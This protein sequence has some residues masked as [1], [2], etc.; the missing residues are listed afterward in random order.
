MRWNLR[1]IW[2]R[3]KYYLK[4]FFPNW[5][6]IAVK[7]PII[8]VI[9]YYVILGLLWVFSTPT[10]CQTCH[11][12]QPYGKQWKE[13]THAN[14]PC[15][16]CHGHRDFIGKIVSKV[17]ALSELYHHITGTYEFPIAP[18]KFTSDHNCTYCHPPTR[19]F[20]LSGDLIDPHEKHHEVHVE[21]PLVVWLNG[22]STVTLEFNGQHCVYCHLNVV[23]ADKEDSRRPQMEFCME[24]CHDGSK[25]T[26]ECDACHT[27]KNVPPS[28]QAADWFEVHGQKQ[29]EEDCAGCHDWR[30]DFCAECHKKRP[31]SHTD[32]WRTFHGDEAR[33]DREGCYACHSDQ[34]CVKCHGVVPE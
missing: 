33:R 8:L 6:H 31:P 5:K 11:E 18:K 17:E 22:E 2:D 7:V 24:N 19:E 26:D 34:L 25:A 30:P 16:T 3:V 21:G 28:H 9:L 20:T 32:T 29:T 27:K 23:H 12:M 15:Y 1:A 13:S 4:R 14:V 10:F